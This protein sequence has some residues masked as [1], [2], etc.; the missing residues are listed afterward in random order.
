MLNDDHESSSL[1]FL[2]TCYIPINS[3]ILSIEAKLTVLVSLTLQKKKLKKKVLKNDVNK[4]IPSL[5]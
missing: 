5:I 2:T 4:R 3:Y 1:T